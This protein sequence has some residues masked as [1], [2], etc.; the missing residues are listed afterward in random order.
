M[1]LVLLEVDA[2]GAEVKVMI[3]A[4][5][6]HF[7]YQPGSYYSHALFFLST[8]LHRLAPPSLHRLIM[9]DA[10]LMFKADIKILHELFNSFS[11]SNVIGIA[12]EMQPVYRHVLSKY[13]QEHPGTLLGEAAPRGFPG[14]NSGVLLLDLDKMRRSVR[15]NELLEIDEV[16]KM[17]E[18]YS[19][20]GHLADQDFYTLLAF[21][22]KE[23]FYVLPST[24]NRQ[25]CQWWK[26]KGY[27]SVFDDYFTYKGKVNIYHGNC[28]TPF[29]MD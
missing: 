23:L 6:Q 17:T 7:S 10:D 12:Y 9:L 29:P 27:E 5:Q 11:P 28:N 16:K 25:L 24:W 8:A 18:K 20:K 15:Y 4:M 14:F 2:L 21:E 26:D 1:Q 22:N 19:F 3:Q 13:R